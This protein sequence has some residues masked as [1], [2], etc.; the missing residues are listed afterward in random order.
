VEFKDGKEIK[1]KNSNQILKLFTNLHGQQCGK[2]VEVKNRNAF[3][4][5]TDY[6]GNC[7][8]LCNQFTVDTDEDDYDGDYEN[9]YED[10]GSGAAEWMINVLSNDN[11][12]IRLNKE[13]FDQYVDI[14]GIPQDRIENLSSDEYYYIIDGRGHP[15]GYVNFVLYGENRN[16]DDIHYFFNVSPDPNLENKKLP[17]LPNG[18]GAGS[19]M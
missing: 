18:Y 10:D 2:I 11:N 9:Y 16:G 14:S 19:N 1:R 5:K 17:K 4:E 7:V 3:T 6:Y 15:N 8:D 12:V 13:T